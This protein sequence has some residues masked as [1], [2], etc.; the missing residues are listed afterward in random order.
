[1]AETSNFHRAAEQLNI[2]QP[3]LSVSIRKLEL[4]LGVTLF[5]RHSRGVTLTPEGQLAVVQAREVVRMADELLQYAR[6]GATGARGKLNLGFVASA[7][8]D[9]IPALVPAFRE[10]FPQ[11]ELG[12]KEATSIDIVSGLIDGLLDVG[13][14]RTPIFDTPKVEITPLASEHMVLAVPK[15]HRL[16]SRSEVA[17]EEL[18][19]EPLIM[20]SRAAEPWFQSLIELSFGKVGIAPTVVEEAS[21]VHTV[22]ALVECGVG[23]A[24]VPSVLRRTGTGRV[25]LLDVTCQGQPIAIGFAIAVRA[26]HPRRIASNFIKVATEVIRDPSWQSLLSPHDNAHG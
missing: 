24:L 2:A 9:L 6:Q 25:R 3:P 20:W 1:L 15:G 10:S 26:D 8:Y 22:L 13:L 16:E 18:G 12:L 11:V 7:T 5:E 23:G 4:D 21:H 17:L 19:S 14:I